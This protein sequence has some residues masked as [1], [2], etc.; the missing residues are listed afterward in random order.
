MM[1]FQPDIVMFDRFGL[2]VAVIEVKALSSTGVG[3]AASYL[4]NLF[5]HGVAPSARFALLITPDEG[6]L[7][8]TPEAVLRHSTPSLTFPMRRIVQHYLPAESESIP[9]RDLVLESIVKQWL[10]DLADGIEV[11]ESVT[12]SLRESG[13]LDAVRDGLVDARTPR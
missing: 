9:V 6:Y 11:D 10:S 12:R 4:R 13:F 3:A 1:Q 5:T 7:W 8:S 2:A